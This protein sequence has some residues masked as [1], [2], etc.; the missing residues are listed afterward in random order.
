MMFVG[1]MALGALGFAADR[2]F[3]ALLP[4]IFPWYGG[5]ARR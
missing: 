4:R 2:I 3:V 1:L 5:D